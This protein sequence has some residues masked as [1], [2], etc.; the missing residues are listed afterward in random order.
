MV[1]VGITVNPVNDAPV[2]GVP[3]ALTVEEDTPLVFSAGNGNP[4]SI[5]DVDAGTGLIEV[6]VDRH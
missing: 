4:I 1:G 5:S 6:K 3:Y 2:N